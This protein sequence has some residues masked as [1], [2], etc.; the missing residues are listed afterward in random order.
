MLNHNNS[1]KQAHT[2][3]SLNKKKC[4]SCAFPLEILTIAPSI[5]N[6]RCGII[7][8]MSAPAI[9]FCISAKR[10]MLSLF[11]FISFKCS[12][13]YHSRIKYDCYSI[14]KLTSAIFFIALPRFALSGWSPSVQSSK[15][16]SRRGY[17]HILC[18]GL[19]R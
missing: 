19:M 5:I 12:R 3:I 7:I 10:C 16:F 18:T 11:R 8:S 17:L 9:F 4:R 14:Q 15:L 2:R 6:F 1:K 13:T